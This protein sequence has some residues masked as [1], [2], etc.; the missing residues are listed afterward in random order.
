MNTAI[1]LL[2][3]FFER[4][5]PDS[6][7]IAVCLTLLTFVLAITVS[8]MAPLAAVDLWSDSFW[9]LLSF[10][11]QIALT[12]LFGYALAS[13]AIVRRLLLRIAGHVRSA[14]MA[15]AIV[16]VVTGVLALLSWSL[17]LVAA[18]ILSRAVGEACK[19]RGVRV[20]YPLLVAS[21]F[22]GFVVWHQGL[23]G[24]IPLTLA[25]PGHF[26]E[27]QVGIIATSQTLFSPW[28]LI[29]AV[30]VIVS[31]PWVMGRLHP[32]SDDAIRE[33]P[34]HPLG[35]P[36]S[37]QQVTDADASADAPASKLE[38]S[39]LLAGTVVALGLLALVR[40]FAGDGPGL[41]LNSVNFTLLMLGILCAGS[42]RTYAQN[43]VAGGG[44]AVPFLLQ[45]PFYAGIAGLIAGSGLAGSIVGLFTTIADTG[46]LPVLGFF[47]AGILNIFIPSGGAQWAVQG[48]IMMG[49]AQQLGADLPLVA[50]SVALGDQ[51]TNLVHPLILLPVLTVAGIAARA[52]IGYSLIAML[53]SG[54][55]FVAA[56]LLAA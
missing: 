33:A 7:V 25:T 15:Y 21:A 4:W 55:I 20:H 39:R 31:L 43:V 47:S 36:E 52:V 49:A 54:L 35:E 23:S 41:T 11:N 44:I 38:R 46:S 50:M 6:L 28:S 34:D 12:L 9:T 26:L 17:A 24:S 30:L 10:T 45:Y 19:R 32:G 42:L 16:S 37:T 5:V 18:G 27:S 48:P 1:G 8:G 29:T 2:V 13:A 56:L 40:Y 51:W 14:R 3:R 53:W 22:S